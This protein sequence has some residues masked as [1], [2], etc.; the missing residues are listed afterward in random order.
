MCSSNLSTAP[1]K[2]ME[3]TSFAREI[4]HA[5]Q[6]AKC[7]A[8]SASPPAVISSLQQIALS[9]PMVIGVLVN[10]GCFVGW[11]KARRFEAT[12]TTMTTCG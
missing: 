5:P 12:P 7:G 1:N 9:F 3:F 11:N 6:M 2:L 4:N 10:N 8:K